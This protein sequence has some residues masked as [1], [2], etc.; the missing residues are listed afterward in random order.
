MRLTTLCK[1]GWGRLRP[2]GAYHG[3]SSSCI[4]IKPLY[5][6]SSVTWLT[7]IP[8][9]LDMD[10][11]VLLMSGLERQVGSYKEDL[12]PDDVTGLDSSA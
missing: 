6:T 10:T 5:S 1:W 4:S 12:C 9:R 3:A 11:S 2:L 7:V 8:V